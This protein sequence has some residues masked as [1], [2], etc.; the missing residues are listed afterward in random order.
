MGFS[1]IMIYDGFHGIMMGFEWIFF[2]KNIAHAEVNPMPFAPSPI[3][4]YDI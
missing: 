2:T 4:A 1:G 3:E